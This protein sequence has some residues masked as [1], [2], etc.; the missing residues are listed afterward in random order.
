MPL[1][2]S[3]G[4]FSRDD[5]ELGVAIEDLV[6]LGGVEVGE[7]GGGLDVAVPWPP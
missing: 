3:F 5:E 4:W 7:H 1:P 6:A 2:S